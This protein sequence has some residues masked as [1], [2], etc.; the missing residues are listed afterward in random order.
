V[1]RNAVRG[2]DEVKRLD[3][4]RNRLVWLAASPA[5]NGWEIAVRKD[6]AGARHL[7]T[8]ADFARYVGEGGAVKLAASAEFVESPGALPA[9]QTAYG[10]KLR[11]DQ[12]LVLAGGD[13]SATLRAAAEGTSRVNAAMAY[14]T[15][16]ALAA[17]GL[18]SLVDD[19]HVQIVYRPA[20]VVRGPVLARHPDLPA[21]LDPV[22]RALSIDVLRTLNARIAVDGFDAGQVARD[23]LSANRFLN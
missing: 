7:Q 15:D 20:P 18:V 19:R 5:D 14:G 16:G 23:F 1:W 2:Y 4:E 21:I 13:T 11:R 12:L 3:L 6:F 22:F 17:L 9:F 10:F 8:L